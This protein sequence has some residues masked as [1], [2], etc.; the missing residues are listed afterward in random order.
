MKKAISC[1]RVYEISPD[2]DNHWRRIE[3]SITLKLGLKGSRVLLEKKVSNLRKKKGNSGS[4]P[5][6]SHAG[7]VP[8]SAECEQWVPK[9]RENEV[10]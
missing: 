5:G 9:K 6:G 4:C 7:K 1:R 3:F 10:K 8:P 2:N